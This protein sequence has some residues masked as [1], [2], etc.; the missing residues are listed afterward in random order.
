MSGKKH[1][2]T[3]W[4]SD[5]HLGNPSCNAAALKSFLS[6][7]TC[8]YLYLV[9]DIID[10]LYI[11]GNGWHWPSEH[12]QVLYSILRKAEKEKTEVT[13][14]AGNHDDFLRE[15]IGE[16]KIEFGNIKIVDECEHI[17]NK[18]D[19]LWVVHGDYWDVIMTSHRFLQ[20]FMNVGY[21]LAMTINRL[22]NKLIRLGRGTDSNIVKLLRNRIMAIVELVEKMER[23]I[24]KET[25][26]RGYDGVV[27]GHSHHPKSIVKN[28]VAYWN[29]G[30][31]VESCTAITEDYA[32]NMHLLNWVES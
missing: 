18:N 30:D 14:V 17:T 21:D 27:C 26:E 28:D 10:V 5:F 19:R 2:R 7:H 1:F 4:I 32:G 22:Y 3:I 24:T 8:D 15:Y 11:M 6:A 9:G 29:T 13:Y 20:S 31:W 12:N 25:K 23:S 16:H